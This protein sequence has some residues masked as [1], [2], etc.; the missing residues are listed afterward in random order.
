MPRFGARLDPGVLMH[1]ARRAAP[2]EYNEV[3]PKVRGASA[4]LIESGMR[5]IW[6]GHTPASASLPGACARL[7]CAMYVRLMLRTAE[8]GEI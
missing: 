4:L 3:T 2:S 5:V 6:A 1:C 8:V 7:S